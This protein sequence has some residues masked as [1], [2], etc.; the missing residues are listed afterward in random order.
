[1][2]GPC[3]KTERQMQLLADS[4]NHS[5]LTVLKQSAEPLDVE[6]VA[7]E[8]VEEELDLAS[9]ETFENQ[10]NRTVI[11]LHHHRLPQL[12]DAGLVEYDQETNTVTLQ[13]EAPV[14]WQAAVPDA[15]GTFLRTA[16]AAN[17]ESIGVLQGR[18][19]IMQ[20][21][22][23]LA[24]EAEEELFCL[25]ASPDL[26]D[27][28]CVIN[29]QQ[30]VA[31]SVRMHMGSQNAKVRDLTRQHV[32]EAT[33]WEPQLDW[34]NTPTFPSIGRLVLVD[35][36]KVMLSVIEEDMVRKKPEEETA[37]LGDG[38]DNPLVV[39]VRELMGPRLDHLDSQL[40]GFGT[41]GLSH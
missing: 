21:G 15:F 31:R 11:S 3:S 27:E 10:L 26:I 4:K 30:A 40:G 18:G 39:L 38:A 24:D 16:P 28:E 8:I 20:C 41:R 12:A 34:M 7:Q 2:T 1:M 35:R 25:Y 17:D 32:P 5:I 19:A 9:T 37:I 36:R 14:D 33:I 22:K 6:A 13:A 23:D 29:A